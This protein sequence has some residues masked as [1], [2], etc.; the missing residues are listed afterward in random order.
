MPCF[1]PFP[2]RQDR[3]GGAVVLWPPVGEENLL[4]PCGTCVGCRQ[5]RAAEWASR[6]V[7]ESS[8]HEHNSFVTLTYDDFNVPRDG[9]LVPEHLQKFLK[10][11]RAG[12]ARSLPGLLGDRLRFLACGE[13]GDKSDRPHYHA[14]LFGCGFSDGYPI[15]KNLYAS[16]VLTRLWGLGHA[17][18][19]GVSGAS[20]AYVAQY[21]LKKQSVRNWSKCDQDG[22]VLQQPF[23]RCSLK[24]GIGASWLEKYKRDCRH[25][26]LVR[27]GQKR[28]VPRYYQKLLELTDVGLYEEYRFNADVAASAVQL[29]EGQRVAGEAIELRRLELE[30]PRKDGL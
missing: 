3:P 20:A 27:D 7:A 11:V 17:S 6:S 24:P 21:S 15:R 4:L 28:P 23:L 12:L 13:Y 14:L 18:Y 26:Y 8:L 2:A 30:N 9:G 19:G 25:G 16:H 29:T 1:H 5:R 22:V 10:R